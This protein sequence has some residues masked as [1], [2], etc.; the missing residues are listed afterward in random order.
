MGL[1]QTQ[2]TSEPLPVSCNRGRVVSNP[3]T[4]PQDL[5]RQVTEIMWTDGKQTRET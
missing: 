1:V 4:T 3:G 2:N 5:E